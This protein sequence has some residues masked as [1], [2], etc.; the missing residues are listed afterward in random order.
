[1]VGEIFKFGFIGVNVVP[2]LLAQRKNERKGP[3]EGE[4]AA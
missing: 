2:S 1:M 3:K 4:A